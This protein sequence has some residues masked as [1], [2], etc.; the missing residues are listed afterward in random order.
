MVLLL[1]KA[2]KPK[3]LEIRLVH[4]EGHSRKWIGK[5]G[6]PKDTVPDTFA[7]KR[8]SYDYQKVLVPFC[9]LSYDASGTIHELVR[10]KRYFESSARMDSNLSPKPEHAVEGTGGSTRHDVNVEPY[11]G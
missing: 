11:F 9:R 10:R 7:H 1:E 3:R 6:N 2:N 8:L 5:D 4:G